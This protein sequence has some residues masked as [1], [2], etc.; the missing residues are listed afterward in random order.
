MDKIIKLAYWLSIPLFLIVLLYVYAM[1][2]FEFKPF[3]ARHTLGVISKTQFFYFSFF[4]MLVP[5]ALFYL[6]RKMAWKL[7]GGETDPSFWFMGLIFL[8]N[9]SLCFVVFTMGIYHSKDLNF[10][11]YEFLNYLGPILIVGWVFYGLYLRSAK[12]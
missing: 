5:N 11:H 10:D 2:P 9:I 6:Y 4:S 3:G 1:L 7:E 12:K 8:I